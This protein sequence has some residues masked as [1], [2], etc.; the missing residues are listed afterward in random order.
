VVLDVDASVQIETLGPNDYFV[1]REAREGGQAAMESLRKYAGE[2]DIPIRGEVVTVG[3][4][5]LSADGEP[6]RVAD[7][8]GQSSRMAPQPFSVPPSIV[9]DPEYVKALSVLDTYAMERAGA[10]ANSKASDARATPSVDIDV[11]HKHTMVR[12]GTLT[13]GKASDA[14]AAPSV[15]IDAFHNAATVVEARTQA[16]SV[17]FLGVLGKSRSASLEVADF[18]GRLVVGEAVA[19]ATAGLG[20]GYYVIFVPGHMTGFDGM[21]LEGALVDLQTGQLTWSNA[22]QVNRDPIHA[23]NMAN[24]ENFDLL[25]HNLM[26]R[27]AAQSSSET[28]EK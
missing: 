13:I 5:R 27:P 16:S 22:V 2:S 25:F 24:K 3:A 11:F 10:L 15:D 23:K 9:N 4:A 19:F 20:T 1:I 14:Q 18:M 6:L 28:M 26:F 7:A 8:A 12:A 21:Y 17:L